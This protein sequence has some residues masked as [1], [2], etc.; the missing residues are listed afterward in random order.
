MKTMQQFKIKLLL[1]IGFFALSYASAQQ[2]T[3]FAQQGDNLAPSAAAT[4]TSVRVIDNRGTIKYLQVGNGLTAFTNQTSNTTMTTW[5]LG[6]TLSDDTYIDVD[7]NIL[8]FESIG[9]VST[10]LIEA[11]TNAV[12]GTNSANSTSTGFTLL[13]RN[14]ANGELLKLKPTDLIQSGQESF[15]ATSGQTTFTLTGAPTLPTFAQV[16]VYRNGAKL[17]ANIDYIVSGADVAL[18]PSSAP[19]N[20]WSVYAGDMIEVHFFK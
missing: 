6:G 4:G 12:S 11:S 9:L 15:T 2:T 18:V 3:D 16:S 1:V 17:I 20:N 19:P 10:T 7:G 8:A 13:V 14:E 5:Q